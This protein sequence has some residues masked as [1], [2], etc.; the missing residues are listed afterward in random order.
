MSKMARLLASGL[1]RLS[2]HPAL[3]QL[4]HRVRV[5]RD[6]HVDWQLVQLRRAHRSLSSGRADVLALGES[7]FLFVSLADRDKRKLPTMVR[8]QLSADVSVVTFCGPGYSP[9]LYREFIRL[10]SG[11]P[12]RP[13]VVLVS[14]SVR[15]STSTHVQLNPRFAYRHSREVL[16][17]LTSPRAPVAAL[18]AR[19]RPRQR[20]G[21]FEEA[22]VDTRWDERRT[23]GEFRERLRGAG[24]SRDAD[25]ERNLFNYFHGEVVTPENTGLEQWAEFGRVLKSFGVPVIAYH[26]PIPLRRGETHFPGEFMD[27]IRANERLV[28]VA[29]ATEVG[30]LLQLV[31]IPALDDADFID[32]GDATEHLAEQGRQRVAKILGAAIR[33]SLLDAPSISAARSRRSA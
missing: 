9:R 10:L 13:G 24:T 6:D 12:P 14:M 11:S 2:L 31:P 8:D 15:T 16:G 27:H 28:E 23:I 18:L 26:A 7:S 29:L 32:A 20:E 21:E 33:A 30:P 19:R 17:R 5:W 1:H 3:I 4:R 22:S 25:T